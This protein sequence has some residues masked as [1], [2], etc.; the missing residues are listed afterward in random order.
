[1]FI[2]GKDFK[3]NIISA[4]GAAYA[5][6]SVFFGPCICSAGAAYAAPRKN[7][8]PTEL[9]KNRFFNF[10]LEKKQLNQKLYFFLTKKTVF[11]RNFN[12]SISIFK[13]RIIVFIKFRWAL[14]MHGPKNMLGAAY[15]SPTGLFKSYQGGG[16]GW[17]GSPIPISP[18]FFTQFPR[19]PTKFLSKSSSTRN[20]PIPNPHQKCSNPQ[21]FWN[22]YFDHIIAPGPSQQLSKCSPT[23]YSRVYYIDSKV[24]PPPCPYGRV[25]PDPYVSV[26]GGDL[27][28]FF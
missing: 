3:M 11:L 20:F 6:P 17:G 25:P 24:S 23:F 12:S 9:Q 27:L 7:K 14:H 18:T 13:K 22:P 1:M 26:G 5:A 28:F 19:I 8:F 2:I 21:I 4:V 10:I 16:G 15:A